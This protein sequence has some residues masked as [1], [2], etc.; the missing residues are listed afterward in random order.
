MGGRARRV[1]GVVVSIAAAAGIALGAGSRR[2]GASWPDRVG[3]AAA[4][5][6]GLPRHRGSTL[7]VAGNERCGACRRARREAP[8]IPLLAVRDVRVLP[9]GIE[10]LERAGLRI[11]AG[12]IPVYLLVSAD[13]SI[14]AA[15]RGYL[16]PRAIARWVEAVEAAP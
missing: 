3:P 4:E 2:A 11:P 15:R 8:A 14:L 12:A 10:E 9:A 7:V 1:A 13:G 5:S 6:L 16:P